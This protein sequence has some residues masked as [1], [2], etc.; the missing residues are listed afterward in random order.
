M[1][2]TI[3]RSGPETANWRGTG[4]CSSQLSPEFTILAFF[5]D[6]EWQPVASSTDKAFSEYITAQFMPDRKDVADMLIARSDCRRNVFFEEFHC[7]Q[8][9]R[10][11]TT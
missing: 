7:L 8:V 4:P 6:E 3:L 10:G 2:V 11:C 1:P 9:E 5:A